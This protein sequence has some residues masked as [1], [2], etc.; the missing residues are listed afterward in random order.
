MIRNPSPCALTNQQDVGVF[1]AHEMRNPMQRDTFRAFH[2]W[3][4]V[5]LHFLEATTIG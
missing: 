2:Y 1:L 5:V 4:H 3:L